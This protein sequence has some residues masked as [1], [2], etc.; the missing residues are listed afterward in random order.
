MSEPT[1]IKYEIFLECKHCKHKGLTNLTLRLGTT[2]YIGCIIC[3]DVTT[4]FV[5]SKYVSW[6]SSS[7]DVYIKVNLV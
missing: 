3:Q 6:S 7:D 5:V 1:H 4:R 2:C